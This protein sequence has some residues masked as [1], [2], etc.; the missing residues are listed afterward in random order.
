M[1]QKILITGGAGFI[2]SEIKNNL[3]GPNLE[4][5]TIG[6]NKKEDIVID[7]NDKSLRQ[8]LEEFSPNIVYHFASGSNIARAN[9]NKE[10]EFN[11]TVIGTK[12]LL[13]NLSV[14]KN[15][16]TFIYLSSQ[17]VYGLP[18]TL[19]ISER[20]ATKP[21]TIYGEN[22]LTIENLIVNSG[23][24]YLI[25]R[26]SSVY[27]AKQDP[28]KSGAIARFVS[29]MK[30]NQSPIVFNGIDHYSDFIYI[31]DLV[32]ALIIAATNVDL[33]VNNIFNLGSGKPTTLKMVL[34]ILYKYFPEAPPPEI[35][36]NPL[37]LIKDQKGLYLDINKIQTQLKWTCKYSI[38]DGLK[39]MLDSIKL[40]R[41]I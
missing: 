28:N 29:K 19:P 12:L 4:I 22:K 21:T 36:E 38:E 17:A 23:I 30:S 35:K 3:K 25:F 7:L 10:K 2:G 39:D 8:V 34:D 9:E 31:K 40:S 14:L 26:V 15:K 20:Q 6:R 18:E 16:P 41:I 32:S 1:K 37:Y 33:I 11:D 24:K 27:G 5:L 13:E